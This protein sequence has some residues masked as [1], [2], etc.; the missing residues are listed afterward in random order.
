MF[1]TSSNFNNVIFFATDPTDKQA[2]MLL[3]GKLLLYGSVFCYVSFGGKM[4]EL[5]AP[6]LIYKQPHV[7]ILVHLKVF[8]VD[9]YCLAF[10][11]KDFLNAQQF[12]C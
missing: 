11:N 3:C 4:C 6:I 7:R 12:D 9:P 10:A 1:S 2:H 8:L 5:N